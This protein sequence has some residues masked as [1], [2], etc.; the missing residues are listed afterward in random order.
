MKAKLYQALIFASI[1]FASAQMAWAQLDVTTLQKRISATTKTFKGQVG[2]GVIDV[3]TGQSWY[4]NGDERFLMQSV[5]KLPVAIATLQMVDQG[6]LKLDQEIPLTQAEVARIRKGYIP[7]KVSPT[8]KSA[9]VNSLIESTICRSNNGAVDALT[10]VIGGPKEVNNVFKAADITGIRFDRYESEIERAKD[11]GKGSELLD[12]ATPRALC[13]LLGKLE[14]G[15]LLSAKSTSYLVGLMGRCE[16]GKNRIA[17]GVPHDWLVAHK[18]GTG[19]TSKNLCVS[20]N[21]VAII[22]RPDKSSLIL[23]VFVANAKSNLPGCE[24]MIAEVARALSTSL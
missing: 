11:N 9:T 15:K 24:N 14:S 1:A 12:S 20:A 22:T 18:T 17:G 3:K 7:E 10:K 8:A 4:L 16:T 23:V 19:P 5:A 2:V 21:D 13:T 6:K